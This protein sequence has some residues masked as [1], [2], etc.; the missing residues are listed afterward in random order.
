[1]EKFKLHSPD[2]AALF[3]NCVTGTRDKS[4]Q[5]EQKS[6]PPTHCFSSFVR[7]VFLPAA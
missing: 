2:L 1:M 3:S 7:L 4:G 5:T 6:N